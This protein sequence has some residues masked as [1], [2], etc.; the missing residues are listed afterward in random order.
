MTKGRAAKFLVCLVERQ[1]GL[2]LRQ[3]HRGAHVPWGGKKPET[4]SVSQG[5]SAELGQSRIVVAC[6]Y[7][8]LVLAGMC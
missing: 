6:V 2:W 8:P 4:E 3:A 5:Y 7:S 1:G